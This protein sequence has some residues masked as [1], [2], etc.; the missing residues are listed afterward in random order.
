MR[1]EDEK[2]LVT[3]AGSH[4]IGRAIALAFAREG[5]DVAIHYHSRPDVAASVVADIKELGRRSFSLQADLSEAEPC[6]QLVRAAAERLGGLDVIVT[7][8]AA[9]YRKPILA[10]TD[11]EWDHMFALNLRGTF[12]CATEAARLMRTNGTRGRIIVIGSIVQQLALAGQVAYGTTKA[13]VA[14]LARGMAYELAPDGITVNVIAPG[15]TLTDFNRDYLSDPEVRQKRI[16]AIPLGR[17]GAPE[18]MA[19]AAVYLASPGASYTTGITIFVD[20]GIMLP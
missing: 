6:R 14:Q 15:A 1:L 8:A 3:G 16:D 18:D 9:I 2:A 7:A 11:D 5:A 13:G 19:E 4:G 17:L 20:G 12:A 10:I